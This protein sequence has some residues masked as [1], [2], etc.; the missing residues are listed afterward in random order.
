MAINS[1]FP[2]AVQLPENILHE[3]QARIRQLIQA[4]KRGI[5]IRISIALI[6]VLFV[7]VFG[8]FALMMDAVAS[9]VDVVS[10][11]LLIIFFKM[12]DKPPDEDHP[13]GHGRYEPLA[14]LQLGLLLIL[15]GGGMFFQQVFQTVVYKHE[16]VINPYIWIVPLTAGLLLEFCYRYLMHIAKKSNSPALEAEAYHYRVD[17]LTSFLAAAALI[18]AFFTPAWGETIDHIGA[19]VISFFMIILGVIAAKSNLNQ[20]LDKI[21]SSEFFMRIKN[22]ALRVPGILDTEKIRI[23]LSGPDAHVDIDIEVDPDL[24]VEL[25]H[26]ISQ[27]ARVEIQKDWPAVR[28][29]TVHIE[30]YYP[31]DH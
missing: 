26:E 14:G 18:A 16:G 27:K 28:D 19:I 22:A 4:S 17:S 1:Q 9:L 30:P 7:V 3:R 21:P 5:F 15:I 2:Q 31:G 25:A 6:E 13:F 23:Q 10:T 11:I 29:V 24:T 12:A 8:S 20:L